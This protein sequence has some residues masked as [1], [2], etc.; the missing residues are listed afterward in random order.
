LYLRIFEINNAIQETMTTNKSERSSKQFEANSKPNTQTDTT[1]ERFIKELDAES[2]RGAAIFAGTFFECT[3]KLLL[4]ELLNNVASTKA[5]LEDSNGGLNTF[6][7]KINISYSLGFITIEEY[8]ALNLLKNIR[9]KFAHNFEY[10]FSFQDQKIAS[11]CVTLKQNISALKSQNFETAREI[12]IEVV[13]HLH[14]QL[15]DRRYEVM[16]FSGPSF[17]IET[18][19]NDPQAYRKVGAEQMEL[20]EFRYF[21]EKESKWASKKQAAENRK[22]NENK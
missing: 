13:K 9:N 1:F 6:S 18:Y 11:Q 14:Q 8:Q 12:F 20:E 2:D 21:K 10:Q 19:L 4:E 3:L 17:K 22:K 15:V 7:A 16:T 5:L